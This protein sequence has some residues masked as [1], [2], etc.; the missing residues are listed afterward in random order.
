MAG[1]GTGGGVDLEAV[2]AEVGDGGE[3]RDE[4]DSQ[5]ALS[6]LIKI[7]PQRTGL[8]EVK[9]NKDQEGC[10][11]Q[12]TACQATVWVDEPRRCTDTPMLYAHS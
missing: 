3:A 5:R 9:G 10:E 6:S 11:D 4:M 8:C 2:E 1:E 12:G 7:R